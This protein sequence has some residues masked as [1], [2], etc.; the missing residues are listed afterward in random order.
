M[1]TLPTAFALCMGLLIRLAIPI[2]ITVVL[3]YFLRKLD[4]RWQTE[5]QLQPI[6]VQKPECWEI[7]DCPPA[8]QRNCIARTS[9]L[10]CW[11]VF[12]STNGYLR[13]ECLI[14]KVFRDAPMVPNKTKENV[15]HELTI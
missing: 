10:P 14:C 3:V 4:A 1:E 2:T 13:A 12:R 8:Q 11:Q 7:K 15:K 5:A 9:P 6:S